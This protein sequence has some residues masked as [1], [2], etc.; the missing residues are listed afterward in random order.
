MTLITFQ[1]GTVVFREGKVGTEQACC[2]QACA[3]PDL[4]EGITFEAEA[5]IG[6]MTVSVSTTVPGAGSQRFD[7]NDGS[8]DYVEIGATVACGELGP[9]GE[10][11]WD[12]GVGVC[13]QSAGFING[14]AY[15]AFQAKDADGCP[16]LG[17]VNL[18]C[19]G[20]CSATVA[21]EIA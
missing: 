9:D 6:G 4:C 11:G 13:Y 21:G 3:C 7:K 8:G 17:A 16:D 15:Q 19:L 5:T 2:C 14:E 12:F 10:C 1:D 20:F 18:Q